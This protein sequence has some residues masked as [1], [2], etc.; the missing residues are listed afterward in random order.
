MANQMLYHVPDRRQAL[1]EI[2][3][4]LRSEVRLCAAALGHHYLRELREMLA[5][6]GWM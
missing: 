1:S 6:S 3:R 2:W 5:R 4:V